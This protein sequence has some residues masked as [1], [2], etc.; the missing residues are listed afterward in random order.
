MLYRK[1]ETYKYLYF[2]TEED[3]GNQLIS[4]YGDI[5]R[6]YREKQIRK[7]ATNG[8]IS[9]KGPI[10]SLDITKL[11]E[12]GDKVFTIKA[13][14]YQFFNN[15]GKIFPGHEI[16][17]L[18]MAN[19]E[20]KKNTETIE[21]IVSKLLKSV[22]TL[23]QKMY[24]SK[25]EKELK[26]FLEEQINGFEGLQSKKNELFSI[27]KNQ[28]GT[29][30][31]KT[32]CKFLSVYIDKETTKFK[33]ISAVPKISTWHLKLKEILDKQI[34]INQIEYFF[35][36]NSSIVNP[37]LNILDILDLA[38][39]NYHGGKNTMITM[40]CADNHARNVIL[41]LSAKEY[42]CSMIRTIKEK[43][44]K[45]LQI[46]KTFYSQDLNNTER[47]QYLER[48]FLGEEML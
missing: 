11:W 38:K 4:K 15:S 2:T 47:W 7:T 13:L 17:P 10:Y 44:K 3:T 45:E 16:H 27:F 48:Y 42:K 29:S 31:N 28:F 18:I 14:V 22:E 34:S 32:S 30:Q 40:R 12:M 39:V 23:C 26:T 5:V 41:S 36:P 35:H 46:A 9:E 1:S 43:Q 8:T 20:L 24:T 6:F 33:R 37:I 25:T 19:V 21:R